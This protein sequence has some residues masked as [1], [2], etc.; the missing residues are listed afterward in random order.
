MLVTRLGRQ[1][2]VLTYWGGALE[3]RFGKEQIQGRN[4]LIARM[5]RY[6]VGQLKLTIFQYG[7]YSSLKRFRV[8]ESLEI[9]VFLVTLKSHHTT[10]RKRPIA[11]VSERSIQK[12]DPSSITQSIGLGTQ[13]FFT[14]VTN[15]PILSVMINIALNNTR[16]TTHRFQC[17]GTFPKKW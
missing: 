5:N 4:D 14:Q 13:L 16:K 3:Y 1:T 12:N 11:L 6:L 8:G 9:S 7:E 17:G 10:S 2:N 15:H